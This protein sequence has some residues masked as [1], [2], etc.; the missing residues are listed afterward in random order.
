VDKDNSLDSMIT[1]GHDHL[2]PL[3]K[4]RK[5]LKEVSDN[6]DFRSKIRRN[7]QPGLGPLTMDARK[8]LL[9]E[10]LAIQ[11][12][13]GFELISKTEVLLIQ[14]QWSVDESETLLRDLEKVEAKPELNT[15]AQ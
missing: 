1:A 6:P 14:E 7:G 3:S 2:E 9:D 12:E 8:M 10:L 13:V 15:C 5:R 4:Y 11:K